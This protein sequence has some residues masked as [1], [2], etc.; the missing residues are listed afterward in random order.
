MKEMRK[1]IKQING[2]NM[3]NTAH[4]SPFML[5][6]GIVKITDTKFNKWIQ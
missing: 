2:I 1:G 5:K 6:S 4:A 3:K